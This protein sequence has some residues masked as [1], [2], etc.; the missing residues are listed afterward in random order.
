MN[1]RKFI[2]YLTKSAILFTTATFLFNFKNK[3]TLNVNDREKSIIEK[4]NNLR[5]N[6]LKKNFNS[7]VKK[8]LLHNKTL[9]IDKKLYTYAEIFNSYL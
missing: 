1:R 4:Y 5:I 3:P 9:W 6:N 7:E 2:S 8:D